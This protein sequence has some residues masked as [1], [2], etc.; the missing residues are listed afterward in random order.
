[1]IRKRQQKRCQQLPNL[2]ALMLLELIFIYPIYFLI[3]QFF[4]SKLLYY[5]KK[6]K[7]FQE[8]TLVL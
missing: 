3:S 1:M 5:K 4:S 2:E 8:T 6:Q 7:R